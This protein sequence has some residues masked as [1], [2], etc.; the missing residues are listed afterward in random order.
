MRR[1]CGAALLLVL[2][3]AGCSQ[4]DDDTAAMGAPEATH[5]GDDSAAD[6]RERAAGSGGGGGGAGGGDVAAPA[7]VAPLQARV[8]RTATLR[9]EVPAGELTDAVREATALAAGLGGFVE[10]SEVSSSDDGEGVGDLTLRVPVD[11]FD[12]AVARLGELG[13]L[14]RESLEGTDVTGELIDLDARLRTLRAEE[15]ALNVILAE[16]RNVGDLL[17]VRGQLTGIRQQIEQLAAQQASLAERSDHS[18]VRVTLHEPRGA[19]PGPSDP[20][21]WGLAKAL[22]T[23]VDAAEAVVGGMVVALGFVTPLV[24]LGLP[25]WLAWRRYGRRHAAQP[26]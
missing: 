3:V 10:A 16:A 9:I 12:E 21:P 7:V 6:E 24:L 1:A 11:R 26:G 19:A 22:R 15:E 25:M 20:D 14:E 2:L 8:V 13:E 4:D 17:A 23:A 18:T 5:A